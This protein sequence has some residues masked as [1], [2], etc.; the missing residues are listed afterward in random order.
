MLMLRLIFQVGDGFHNSG[1]PSAQWVGGSKLSKE[2][3]C[4]LLL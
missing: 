4:M 3:F 1:P 2:Q